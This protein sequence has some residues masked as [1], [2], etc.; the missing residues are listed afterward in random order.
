MP[1]ASLLSLTTVGSGTIQQVFG[2][3][4]S[5]PRNGRGDAWHCTITL[6]ACASRT[7]QVARRRLLM[8]L[9]ATPWLRLMPQY[10][11]PLELAVGLTNDPRV[12]PESRLWPS[13]PRSPPFGQFHQ[14]IPLRQSFQRVDPR[15]EPCSRL[16]RWVASS[17]EAFPMRRSFKGQTQEIS[18]SP[19]LLA[20]RIAL[21][22]TITYNPFP[23][24]HPTTL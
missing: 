11:L 2:G 4:R 5:I 12:A 8:S 9:Y 22:D 7:K 6:F 21:S 24:I 23:T 15:R 1:E 16:A 17:D 20:A 13:F 10:G 14:T 19:I 3:W 18:I